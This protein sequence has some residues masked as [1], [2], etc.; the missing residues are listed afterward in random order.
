MARDNT[1]TVGF[2]FKKIFDKKSIFFGTNIINETAGGFHLINEFI[3]LIPRK[4]ESTLSKIV[5]IIGAIVL[6]TEVLNSN[7]QI[8]INKASLIDASTF[9]ENAISTILTPDESHSSKN[10]HFGDSTYRYKIKEGYI[11]F[12]N[13]MHPGLDT[14]KTTALI[15]NNITIDDVVDVIWEKLGRVIS[16]GA[17][18]VVSIGGI[19]ELTCQKA[20][21]LQ[22]KIFGSS[23]K[24]I[25]DLIAD[26][27]YFREKNVSRGYLLIGK[28]GTGK[29]GI[30]NNVANKIGNKI[31]IISSVINSDMIDNLENIL[32]IMKPEFVIFDD[33]D[34]IDN[35]PSYVRG[36][37]KLLEVVKAKTP[38]TNFLFIANSFSGILEDEAIT[39]KGR[40]DKIFEITEPNDEDRKQIILGY[41][42]DMNSSIDEKDLQ[43]CVNESKGMSGSDI[44]ELCIQLG[45]ASIDE[46]LEQF[47]LVHC[48][49]NQYKGK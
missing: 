29:T 14:Q 18:K 37:L 32:I 3:Q 41:M 44:K 46:I 24:M 43:R 17:D 26:L 10:R 22:K 12:A 15:S 30:V 4:N 11:Y 36:L 28:P 9:I 19:R 45:R 8:Q 25:D 2:E 21:L 1:K 39:R 31:I 33:V 23:T 35:D 16:I 47:N 5:K 40:I 6:T 27:Q 34:R 42:S 7:K 20:N 48:L 49:K 13:Q 38:H